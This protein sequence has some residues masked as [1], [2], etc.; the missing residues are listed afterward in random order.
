MYYTVLLLLIFLPVQADKRF[1]HFCICIV[2]KQE[3]R[4]SK[5][6]EKRERKRRKHVEAYQS[7]TYLVWNHSK[8]QYH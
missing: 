2:Y 7:V 4:V 6:K 8:S 5:K 1:L 3:R